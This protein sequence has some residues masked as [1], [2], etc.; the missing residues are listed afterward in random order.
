MTSRGG[1]ALLAVLLV[2]FGS[3]V[4]VAGQRNEPPAALG[5]ERLGPEFGEPVADYLRRAAESLPPPGADQVWAL[6]QLDGYL[7][8]G[9][10]AELIPRTRLSQVV[11]RVAL[12]GVQTSLIFRDVPGQHPAEELAA[13]VRAAG[14]DR[15][16]AAAQVPPG[17]RQAEVAAAEAVRLRAGCACVLALLVRTD[18]ATLHELSNHPAVRVVHAAASDTP[19]Q[20]LSVAPLL[21]EQRDVVGPVADDGQVPP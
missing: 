5:T 13:A 10:A 14:L 18:P 1:A 7:E 2:A 6:V 9:P 19:R 16:R 20:G 12:P 3:A 8:P 11:L 4:V 15:D 21:P 17:S